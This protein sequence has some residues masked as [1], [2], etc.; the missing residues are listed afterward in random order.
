MVR[1]TLMAAVAVGVVAAG[2]GSVL[3]QQADAPRQWG[4]KIQADLGLTDD[5]A[6]SLKELR[7]QER[8]ASMGRWADLRTTRKELNQLLVAPQLDEAAIAAQV[9]KLAALQAASVTA[10]ANHD[11]AVR[12]LVTPEQFQKMQQMR[13]RFASRGWRGRG[14][15][16]HH[17]HKGGAPSGG[18]SND[19]AAPTA[20]ASTQP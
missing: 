18:D 6:A 14:R 8:Q 19:S 11:I 7:R 15:G 9:Q 20:P 2:A 13:T 17:G 12:K 5:Q 3:A 1:N 10:Q 4:A 16:W